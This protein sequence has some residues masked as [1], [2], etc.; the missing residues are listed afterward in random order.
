ML[1]GGLQ[2]T[3][4]IDFPGRISCVVFA[5]GCNFRCPFCHNPDLVLPADRARQSLLDETT[6]L[7]FLKKRRGLL[8]GV[9]IS[10]GEPTL[11]RGLV[12]FCHKLRSLGYF[13]KLD[14]NGSRPDILEKLFEQ[15]LVDYVAMD[16]KT[17]L[18]RYP[19]AAGTAV[20]T[21]AIVES[22]DLILK[23]APDSEFRTTCVKPFLD[24]TVMADIGK[25]IH[26]APHY[27]LQRCQQHRNVLDPAFFDQEHRLF[28]DAELEELRQAAAPLVGRCTLR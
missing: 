4:L 20:D 12:S 26:R 18:D 16:I 25:R 10:G 24:K 15:N 23:K 7:A 11:S 13:V 17:S 2:K 21:Q 9:V 3:S 8:D 22:I 14:T 5:Q 19:A 27:I 1:I 28:S 6:V